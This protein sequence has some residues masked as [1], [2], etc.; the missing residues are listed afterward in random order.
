MADLSNAPTSD[1]GTPPESS[2]AAHLR[3]ELD[4][5]LP[6]ASPGSEL[7]EYL[8]VSQRRRQLFPRAALVGLLAGTVAV[9]FRWLLALG[10]SLRLGFTAWAHQF[11]A[12][13]WIAPVLW[14]MSG[15]TVA[16]LLVR[17]YAPE[18]SGSGIP[19]IKAVLLRLRP[20][21]WKHILPVKMVGGTIAL[22]SGMALGREG[23]TV[24]MGG[25]VGAA[26]AE[27]LNS[28][29][30]DRLALIAAG[31]GAGLAAAF[32]AP[33]AG[34]VFV[35][36]ELQRDFRRG[37]FGA[38][39]IAAAVADIVTR[40][41]GGQL[42]VFHIPS[43]PVPPLGALPFFAI[44]GIAAGCLGVLFNRGLLGGLSLFARLQG[45]RLWAATAAVGAAAGIIAWFA[46]VWV[47]GGHNLSESLLVGG[48][49]FALLPL[50]FILRFLLTIFSY[51]TGAPGGIFAPLLV[52]GSLLGLAVGNLAHAVAPTVVPDP[53]AMAVVGMAA[54]FTAIV[55]APLTGIVLIVEMTGN[56]NQMLP[57][58]VA[59]F[60]ASAVAELL[61]DLPV[62]ESLLRRDLARGGVSHAVSKPIVLDLEIEL[63]APFA[64]RMI[65][66]IGLPAGCIIVRCRDGAREWV[67]KATTTLYAHMR[68]TAIV[69]ADAPDG[70]RLLREG[71]AGPHQH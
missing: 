27:W 66:E 37:V 50:I 6:N 60:F 21:R 30:R 26:V 54:Y 68:L 41:A 52:L 71:C 32:N 36:E 40:L 55:R 3:S 1:Q 48:I 24:Q 58:L 46:P 8:D 49:A 12:V 9:T 45:W 18:S 25:A 19:H 44:L 59:C 7:A 67:P 11:P 2:A 33:L 69:A 42:P 61:R 35:L 47:G 70:L 23:P 65:R 13:G 34:L 20:L 63:G 15:A 39:F 10:E 57:L 31:A 22:S 4:E 62:Y 51:A 56:Y 53:G 28:S 29:S 64:G 16:V 38:T 14:G 43:Y 17:R 5:T